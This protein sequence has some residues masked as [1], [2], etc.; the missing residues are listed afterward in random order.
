MFSKIMV[1]VDLGHLETLAPA[2]EE[3]GR[4][5]AWHGAALCYVGVTAAT[6]G[7]L[8]HTPKEFA[9]RLDAF[10]AGEGARCG[11]PASGHAIISHDPAVDLNH[12]LIDAIRETGADLVVM[13]SH[14]P[15]WAEHIFSSHAG[16][17]ASHAPI[18]VMVI[19]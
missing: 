1:P 14:R 11:R 13:G 2:L 19:R 3:A 10:A 16:Y 6:P 5:A 12:R 15:G 4:L 7:P 17:V 9:A 18:S 8:G